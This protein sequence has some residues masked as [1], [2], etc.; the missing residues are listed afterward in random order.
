MSRKKQITEDSLIEAAL[1]LATRMPWEQVSLQDIA[2]EAGATLASVHKIV[3]GK[4]EVLA[5]YERQIDSILLE[6]MQG[7]FS[8]ETPEREKLFDILMERF[9]IL[10]EHKVAIASIIDA[11][12]LNP[13]HVVAGLPNIM[14]SMLWALEL[15]EINVTGWQGCLRVTGLTGVYLFTLKKFLEDETADLS[16]TMAALDKALGHAEKA[17][18]FFNL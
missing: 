4:D 2:R 16:K 17:A 6:R 9:D 15:A 18:E 12:K 10:N 14:R 1:A 11:A 5:A 3:K 13:H 7:A 8:A